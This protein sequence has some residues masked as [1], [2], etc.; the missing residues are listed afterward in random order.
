MIG[1]ILRRLGLMIPTLFG[2]S[3]LVFLF[4]RLIPGDIVLVLSGARGDVSPEQRAALRADLG[5]DRPLLIQYLDWLFDIVRGDMGNSLMTGRSIGPDIMSRLPVTIELALLATLIGSVV[6]LAT[7]I[8][9]AL[10]RGTWTEFMAQ[11]VGLVGL[12]MPDYWLGTL[13]L[14]VA[15]RY[16]GWYPGARYVDILSDP[17]ANLSM[18]IL[19]AIAVGIGLSASL[20]RITRSTLLDVL[21]AGYIVTARSK[22]L[23]ASVVLWRHALKN[24]LIPIVTILGLQLGYL[25]GGVVIV[26]TVFNLPG[27]GRFT[28]DA[29]TARDYPVVQA[30]VLLITLIVLLINLI[31]DVLYAFLDPRIKYGAGS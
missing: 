9:A 8:I 18:F 17:R 28:V 30:T 4:V 12:S 29:I 24:A 1:Y 3:L 13:F 16:F 23:R 15:S 11:G 31:V 19:P 5:L 20:M 21:G 7:G 2:V 27:V 14:L 25:L 10:R 6:G 22:G 26:E